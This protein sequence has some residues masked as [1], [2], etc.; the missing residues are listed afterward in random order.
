ML[1]RLSDRV[2]RMHERLIS[3]LLA[4]LRNADLLA[5]S[6]DARV[7]ASPE[8]ARTAATADAVVVRGAIVIDA[9]GV[10][11]AAGT[12]DGAFARGLLFD[13]G[14][15]GLGTAVEERHVLMLIW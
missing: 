15:G 4:F 13:Y 7:L 1:A 10:G 2:P 14:L 8:E 11:A 12:E 5:R 6:G 3:S 9:L